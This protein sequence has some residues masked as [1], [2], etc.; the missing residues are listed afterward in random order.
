MPKSA[1][2]VAIGL[3]RAFV[4]NEAQQVFSWGAKSHALG[5][6]DGVYSFHHKPSMSNTALTKNSTCT[7]TKGNQST[8]DK[9]GC[10][11]VML[12]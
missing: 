5:Q 6:S 8:V 4:I 12:R 3:R 2:Q 9:E 1:Q 7:S 10:D 11:G